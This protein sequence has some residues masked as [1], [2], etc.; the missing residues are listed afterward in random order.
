M[1]VQKQE[2]LQAAV[3]SDD[4]TGTLWWLQAF[5]QNQNILGHKRWRRSTREIASFCRTV[6]PQLSSYFTSKEVSGVEGTEL[7]PISL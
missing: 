3:R 1:D 2:C 5:L 6:S 4:T 7:T